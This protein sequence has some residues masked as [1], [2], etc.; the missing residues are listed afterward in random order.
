M[1]QEM[2]NPSFNLKA[3]IRDKEN[4]AGTSLKDFKPKS[5]SKMTD[6]EKTQYK[7]R[8][9]KEADELNYI[10]TRQLNDLD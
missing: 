3:S 1:R 8:L 10:I 2:F 7:N 5:P 4:V 9:F 6:E